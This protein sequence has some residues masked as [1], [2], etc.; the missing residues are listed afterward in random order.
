MPLDRREERR[1]N[2][3]AFAIAGGILLVLAAFAY[4]PATIIG[5][6]GDALAHSVGVGILEEPSGCEQTDEGR[7]RCQLTFG[8]S[9]ATATVVTKAFG[10]WDVIATR[11]AAGAAFREIET[12]GCITAFDLVSPL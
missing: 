7:W 8:S 10:C 3:K 6:N 5:V 11:P 9:S 4:R 1:Q 2:V 12:S